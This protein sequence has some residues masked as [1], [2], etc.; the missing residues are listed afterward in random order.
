MKLADT[1]QVGGS[2]RA[3]SRGGDG[4]IELVSDVDAIARRWFLRAA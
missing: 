4:H 3:Q 2:E 1:G